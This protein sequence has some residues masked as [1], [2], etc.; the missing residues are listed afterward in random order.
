MDAELTALLRKVL[1]S[2]TPERRLAVSQQVAR[3]S[4]DALKE[5]EE[6]DRELD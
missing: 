2:A 1:R 5:L 6:M 4:A 3:Q